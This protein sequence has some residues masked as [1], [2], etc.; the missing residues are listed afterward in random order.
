M[1]LGLGVGVALAG[2]VALAGPAQQ[3][4]AAS[5]EKIVFV[6][7]RT[8]GKGVSNPTG[9]P[10]IFT[11]SPKGTGVRQLTFNQADDIYPILS[12]DGQKIA[13]ESTGSQPSNP[14]GDREVYL[15]NAD[16]SGNKN[17]T[18][19]RAILKDLAPEFSPDGQRIAYVSE[20]EQVGNPQADSEIYAMN[21]DGSGQTNLTNNGDL[22]H[23]GSPAF[24]PDG[25]KIAYT[26]GGQQ[27]SNPEGD[28]EVYVMNA[29]DG[30]GQTN[31]TY[32]GNLV[33]DV[34]PSF[35]P[36][37][38]KI[39]YTSDG[40]Q[41]SNPVGGDEVYVM[42]S[43]GSNQKNLTNNGWDTGDSAPAFSPDGQ[44]VLYE[45]NVTSSSNPDGDLEVYAMSASDGTGKKN[46]TNNGAYDAYPEW[47]R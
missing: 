43:D 25:Q 10:E 29:S 46:L 1:L 26:S 12:P 32:N 21:L 11:M 16:G 36:D 41:D 23:E 39:A 40:P 14:E 5:P 27:D 9:D 33:A 47:G 35:S 24:S 38:Q 18:D 31:L 17:L 2:V 3:A 28:Q 22:L 15:V 19:N 30:S 4:E 6:S 8:T 37:G 34:E 20:G 45:T 13:Y 42:N 7:T 44:R